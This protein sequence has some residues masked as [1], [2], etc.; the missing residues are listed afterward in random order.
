MSLCLQ[1]QGAVPLSR[2]LQATFRANAPGDPRLRDGL[3]IDQAFSALRCTG[4]VHS[5]IQTDNKY[6]ESMEG[7]SDREAD[8]LPPATSIAASIIREAI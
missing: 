1:V 8:S 5:W 2:L 4:A 3:L 6:S 7:L